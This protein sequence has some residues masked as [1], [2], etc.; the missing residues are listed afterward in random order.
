MSLER[1]ASLR[2]GDVCLTWN[3]AVLE[4]SRCIFV[5][6][7][8]GQEA[9]IYSVLLVSHRAAIAHL[10]AHKHAG[11]LLPRDLFERVNKKWAQ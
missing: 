11:H 7:L 1:I 5:S 2:E 8:R 4:C 9:D 3:C 6:P 10:L